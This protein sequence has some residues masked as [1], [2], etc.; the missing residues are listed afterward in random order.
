[1]YDRILIATDGSELAARGLQHGLRLA[2][3]LSTPVL[4][5]T[6]TEPWTP[7]FVDAV[8]L[9]ADPSLQ[10]EYR[11]GCVQSAEQILEAAAAQAA[12]LGVACTTVHVPEGYPSEVIVAAAAEHGAGLVVMASHGRSGLGRVLLGS[13]TQAVLS[14]STVP[15]LV[16][17]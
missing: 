2:A 11:Q 10:Q 3:A 15:V 8:A 1:M 6:V 14:H 9:A 7:A 5:L 16:V 17:R 13:Q 4:V 12:A